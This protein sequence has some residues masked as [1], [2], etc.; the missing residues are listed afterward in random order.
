[1]GFLAQA[2][3]TSWLDNTWQ[4]LKTFWAVTPEGGEPLL[5]P[6]EKK[7]EVHRMAFTGLSVKGQTPAVPR[8]PGRILVVSGTKTLLEIRIIYRLYDNGTV[9]VYLQL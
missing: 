8:S 9:S 7:L 2:N 3:C 5:T 4:C 6:S 1:M